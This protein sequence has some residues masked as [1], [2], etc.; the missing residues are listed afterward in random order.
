MALLANLRRSLRPRVR[1]KWTS[2]KPGMGRLAHPSSETQTPL[3]SS[4]FNMA[5]FLRL[6]ASALP[7]STSASATLPAS[8]PPSG[9]SSWAQESS[10]SG[11]AA[12]PRCVRGA[13][14][15]P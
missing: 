2:L 1:Q 6:S 4:H 10:S 13:Y 14:A 11:A 3:L 15:V 9:A 5:S 12:A 7:L 8:K